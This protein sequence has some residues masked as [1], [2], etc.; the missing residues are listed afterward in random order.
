MIALSYTSTTTDYACCF[1]CHR[2]VPWFRGCKLPNKQFT[3]KFIIF[4]PP[5]WPVPITITSQYHGWRYGLSH[6]LSWS[7][8][9][10]WLILWCLYC[11]DGLMGLYCMFSELLPWNWKSFSSLV[12]YLYLCWDSYYWHTITMM[13]MFMLH[14]TLLNTVSMH[15][16]AVARS[17]DSIGTMKKHLLCTLNMQPKIKFYIAL[18]HVQAVQWMYKF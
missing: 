9:S 12:I 8:H 7:T 10:L 16:F 14:W 1:R 18:M 5:C 4:W 2:V 17:F 15:E 13:I 11:V 6:S 3:F